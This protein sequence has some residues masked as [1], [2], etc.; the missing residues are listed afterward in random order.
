MDIMTKFKDSEG[1][2]DIWNV[3]TSI[4]G[5]VIGLLLGFAMGWPMAI[6]FAGL[7]YVGAKLTYDKYGSSVK[8][9]ISGM[10]RPRDEAEAEA[11]P[12][13][14]PEPEVEP[15]TEAEPTEGKDD[16]EPETVLIGAV[17]M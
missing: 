3:G 16:D 1:K 14:E 17:V 4:V 13:P 10:F 6:V 15:A 2:V 7:G 8:V 9:F 11:K 12:E 5:A